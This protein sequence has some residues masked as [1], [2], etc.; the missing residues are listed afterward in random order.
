MQ[1]HGRYKLITQ[2]LLVFIDLCLLNILFIGL[3]FVLNPSN[4]LLSSY[5]ELLVLFNLSYFLSLGVVRIEKNIFLTPFGNILKSILYRL[6]V[7]LLISFFCSFLTKNSSNISREFIIILSFLLY[8]FTVISH[9]LIKRILRKVYSKQKNRA[10]AIIIGAGTMGQ[11]LY[12]ELADPFLGIRV[13]GFFDDDSTKN[14]NDLLGTVAEIEAYIKANNNVEKIYCTLPLSARDRIKQLLDFSEEKVISFHII[15]T[16]LHYV[17]SP[18][19]LEPVGGMPVFS[20]RKVPLGYAHNAILKRGFDIAVSSLFLITLFP[21]IYIILGAIIKL[22]SPGPVFFVQ[23]RTGKNGKSFRCY[24]FRSMRV[25]KDA[26]KLQ[27]TK[28]DPRKTRIGDFMRKT[29]L[30]E[31]PQFI[32][33]LRGD[34]SIVGPRPH[35]RAH[36]IH[37]SKIVEKYMVRHFIKPGIT[38]WAQ[39]N[40]FRGETKKTE[41]MEGRINKDIWYIENWSLFLDVEIMLKTVLVSIRGDKKAY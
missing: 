16:I 20:I 34:M 27:A 23:K 18:I 2:A 11:R 21:I 38:G 13:L 10:N 19:V 41:E 30:D 24:K 40:G 22:S 26:N 28:N 31:L 33:V 39:I 1:E 36:T 12:K 7:I 15:P 17:D 4:T 9:L 5:K 29:N 3:F 14:N 6:C 8:V 37:Y 35:M 25:N 32:N